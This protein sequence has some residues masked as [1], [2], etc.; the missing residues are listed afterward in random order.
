MKRII[1]TSLCALLCILNIF[2]LAFPAFAIINL[3]DE[4][5]VK[6]DTVVDE[7]GDYVYWLDTDDYGH[8]EGNVITTFL[9]SD[10]DD[11][12][13]QTWPIFCIEPGKALQGMYSA[14]TENGDRIW[15]GLNNN[16][17]QGI[18]YAITCGVYGNCSAVKRLSD[19]S[20]EE[21]IFATQLIVWECVLGYRYG[22]SDGFALK[23]RSYSY[24]DYAA[25]PYTQSGLY[26]AYW[27]INDFMYACSKTP[28][29]ADSNVHYLEYDSN[30]GKYTLTVRDTN[31][32]YCAMS[33]NNYKW[34]WRDLNVYDGNN[35]VIPIYDDMGE[36]ISISTNDRDA[37]VT[38]TSNNPI[39][40]P[41]QLLTYESYLQEAK[42]ALKS[43]FS[44]SNGYV[45]EYDY[46]SSYQAL[47]VCAN[48]GYVDITKAYMSIQTR[49]SSGT[50][51]IEKRSG[52][53]EFTGDNNC[54]SLEN[55]EFTAFFDSA[56]EESVA[57]TL[58]NENG[59][60]ELTLNVGDYYIKETRAPKGYELS[61]RVYEIS[62]T[63]NEVTNL[64]CYDN[65]Q[66]DPVETA[67]RKVNAR[68]RTAD[69]TL[70]NAHYSFSYYKGEVEDEGLLQDVEPERR[71]VFKTDDRGLITLSDSCFIS[72]DPL[73]TSSSGDYVIPLGTVIVKEEVAPTGYYLDSNKY[74]VEIA[75]SGEG[76]TVESYVPPLSQERERELIDINV[77][78]VWNDDNNNDGIRPNSVI[79]DLYK[80]NVFCDYKI[81][82]NANMFTSSFT[83]LYQYDLD[84]DEY[85]YEVKERVVPDGYTS[86]ISVTNSN[87]TITNTHANEKVA[88][89]GK[90]TWE[91]YDNISSTRPNS[92]TINLYKN[93]IYFDST[94]VSESTNWEYEFSNLNKY[95]NFGMPVS[96]TID[97]E[98]VENYSKHIT[99]NNIENSV[100]MGK[101]KVRK[102]DKNQNLQ[103]VEFKLYLENGDE[104]QSTRSNS[105]YTIDSLGT[106]SYV[107]DSNGEF[108][109]NL[110]VGS[111][112]L[113]EVSTLSSYMPYEDE[114]H[115]TISHKNDTKEI[116]VKNNRALMYNTGSYGN[117]IFYIIASVLMLIAV[118][119]LI[120]LII[121]NRKK[122]NKCQK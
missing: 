59:I 4:I 33:G 11:Y 71:W 43:N 118:I 18:H 54:Y 94:T 113:K 60:A 116:V 75:S 77:T 119:L 44:I 109:I 70:Q 58:T 56:C 62:I 7:D 63:P 64:V 40:S 93:G 30:S 102:T 108:L 34:Y 48:P 101:V 24:I 3:P 103:G 83:D 92:I 104:I 111:Y 112:Y 86:N 29:F 89:S 49:D 26:Y 1:K 100:D 8:Y 87:V 38:I 27:Y 73:Y 23:N 72:G 69:E 78:K 67:L 65:P 21:A 105:T 68:T 35:R 97:E 95:Y 74:V 120:T 110:P 20:Y 61:N 19:C 47:M 10:S 32:C 107:T 106:Y 121:K 90:K 81:L 2:A 117:L 76:Q 96:Y 82:D 115:F 5:Y 66:F 13:G 53:L 36:R 46:S 99:N 57:S 16:I 50:L 80:D 55:A 52:N 51:E 14:T 17:K 122:D 37:S 42:N 22:L 98:N 114:I 45:Y 79:V 15:S 88:L 12:D 25:T 39:S 84:G 9:G 91:D 85:T 6:R 31:N 28:S 41:I